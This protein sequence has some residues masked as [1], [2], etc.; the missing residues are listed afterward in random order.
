MSPQGR[1]F[2]WLP[3]DHFFARVINSSAV[4]IFG[5]RPRVQVVV[6]W[7]GEAAPE[8]RIPLALMCLWTG[9]V[10]VYLPHIPEVEVRLPLPPSR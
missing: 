6:T 8:L 5:V 1:I 7:E 9:I 4:P 3:D 2:Y 10:M